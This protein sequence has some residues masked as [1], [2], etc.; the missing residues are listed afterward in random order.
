MA[1]RISESDHTLILE[2]FGSSSLSNGLILLREENFSKNIEI[3]KGGW[4]DAENYK[5]REMIKNYYGAFQQQDADDID[6]DIPLVR[7]STLDEVPE[8]GRSFYGIVLFSEMATPSDY[9]KGRR[10]HDSET[11]EID[12][13]LVVTGNGYVITRGHYHSHPIKNTTIITESDELEEILKGPE[14]LSGKKFSKIKKL[15]N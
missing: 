15:I 10:V 5:H 14:F 2:P 12:G 9:L 8:I 6:E 4:L 3:E 13:N 7:L 11:K 1:L